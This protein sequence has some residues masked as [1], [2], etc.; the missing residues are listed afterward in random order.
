IL[1]KRRLSQIIERLLTELLPLMW[2]RTAWRV[3]SG[4]LGARPWLPITASTV[5]ASH[6]V[7]RG[8][9]HLWTFP[10]T[11]QLPLALVVWMFGVEMTLLASGSFIPTEELRQLLILRSLRSLPR[12][13]TLGN[14]FGILL[15]HLVSIGQQL[16]VLV[17]ILPCGLG[18]LDQGRSQLAESRLAHVGGC[19]RIQ[20]T[21]ATL[22]HLPGKTHCSA[23]L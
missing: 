18:V 22:G 12:L 3:P 8:I 17:V 1:H 10:L 9:L 21:L 11:V 2:V 5:G 19:L 15:R 23:S 20:N 13:P 7:V 4:I 6:V 14:T 16:P